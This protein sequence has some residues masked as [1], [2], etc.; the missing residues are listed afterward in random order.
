VSPF[1]GTSNSAVIVTGL[2][3]SAGL[4]FNFVTQRC[5]ANKVLGINTCNVQKKD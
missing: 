3:A 5:M 2:L 1:G 4:G